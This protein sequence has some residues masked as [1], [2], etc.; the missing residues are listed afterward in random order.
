MPQTADGTDL[1]WNINLW[2]E[3]EHTFWK[4][5]NQNRASRYDCDLKRIEDAAFYKVRVNENAARPSGLR[6]SFFVLHLGMQM[7]SFHYGSSKALT[8]CKKNTLMLLYISHF[9]PLFPEL[10]NQPAISLAGALRWRGLPTNYVSAVMPAH[11]QS[12]KNVKSCSCLSTGTFLSFFFGWGG[13]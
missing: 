6:A 4:L 11:S 3:E 10:Y 5:W 1:N 12:V 7:N 13:L 9:V 8:D 2:A